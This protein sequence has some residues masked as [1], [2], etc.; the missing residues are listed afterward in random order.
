MMVV[1][2]P[3]TQSDSLP[4]LTINDREV[5]WTEVFGCMQLFG[6]LKPFL[7]TFI[8]QHVL[9]EEIN[10]RDDLTVTSADVMQAI[11]DFRIQKNLQEQAEFEA[12]LTSEHL[13]HATFQRKIVLE[14]MVAQLKEKI[15]A[16]D[17]NDYFEENRDLF[18]ELKFSCLVAKDEAI[19]HQLKQAA[20]PHDRDFRQLAS[21]FSATDETAVNY[22]QQ[23]SVKGSL[24]LE[25]RDQ[26]GA[27]SIGEVVGPILVNEVWS[28]FRVEAQYPAELNDRLKPQI[29]A[30]LFNRW[31]TE[32]LQ[33]RKVGM[34]PASSDISQEA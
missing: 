13:D 23:Q 2:P 28:I 7:R 31:L 18:T 24:P 6:K 30:T 26:L 10:R 33:S 27:A 34:K 16:P 11:M 5:G 19:A 17:I 14:I 15:A 32:Q 20:V 3:I 25:I 29:E 21:E 9:L 12:W 8:S 22:F 1:R 4:V